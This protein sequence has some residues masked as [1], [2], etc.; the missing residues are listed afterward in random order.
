MAKTKKTSD[1][2]K[3][4]APGTPAVASA[5]KQ[6]SA[7]ALVES[8]RQFRMLVQGVAD[9]AIYTLDPEGRITNWNLGGE[10][11]KGYRPDEVIS[12]H[13]SMFYTPE[14]RAADMPAHALGTAAREGRY[15]S[16]SWRV[17][18]DGT[19]FW[20][21]VVIDRILDGNGK[22]IG[23][24][25]ITRDLTEKR[26]AEQELEE[27]RAALAQA[28][29]MEAVGQLTGGV[30]HD[31]NNLLTVI[32]NGL[33]L[34]AGPLR[35]EAQKR[36]IIDSAQRAAERG[37]R[38]T[39]Q[40]LAFARRQP[41]RPEIHD[42]NRLI[43]EFE[44]VL[45]RACPEPIEVELA[46]SS[47]PIAANIDSAQFETALLNLMVN[48]RDAMPRGGTVRIGTGSAGIG[49]GQAKAMP[50]IRPGEYV[51]VSI[52]DTGEGMSAEVKSRAFEPFFTTK[53]VGKGSGLGLSQV[54]GFVT[55]SGGH[56]GIDS[57]P[58]AGTTVTLYLPAARAAAHPATPGE[59]AAETAP[60]MGRILVV[61]DDPEVLEVTVETLRTMG[62]EVLTATDGPSGLA[63]LRRD[64]EIDVLF[65]DIVMPRGINGVELAREAARLR[66]ELRILL[67]SG[68]PK[69][70]LSS[71]HGISTDGEFAFLSKPYRSSELA[72]KLRHLEPQ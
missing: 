8:E 37:A 13:F 58:G 56:I 15:E 62:Y 20:A 22:L 6:R 33:D 34:L 53:D 29:K 49:A 35:D 11:I 21:S 27:A 17:R 42:V 40:L 7:H 31:F 30:A 38:L 59:E 43:G 14:D 9:Y 3:P 12:R 51:T 26:R 36:R 61:E 65:T 23:F 45:R 52:N 69:R 54:Y 5:A 41:L 64:P 70:A 25:K 48:A 18:K 46:P 60:G 32:T 16:E 2:D 19:R 68:Y 57:K 1:R 39:Q 66:P 10:R 55:Q 67:A 72:E 4:Q 44:A 47:V 63:V 28:Q 24:A 71:E 50:G